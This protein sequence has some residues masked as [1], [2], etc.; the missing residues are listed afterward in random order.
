MLLRVVEVLS[1]VPLRWDPA[2][3]CRVL[4]LCDWWV[5]LGWLKLFSILPDLASAAE[6]APMPRVNARNVRKM[7]F[8]H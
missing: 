6:A 2:L 7:V 5:E 4:L 8:M 1:L 3:R